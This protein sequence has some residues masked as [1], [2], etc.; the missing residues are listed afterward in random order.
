MDIAGKQVVITATVGDW[1][2]ATAAETGD[3]RI[4]R[5]RAW[6]VHRSDTP[7]EE[8]VEPAAYAMAPHPEAAESVAGWRAVMPGH[9]I[10]GTK[11]GFGTAP[12]LL[13]AMDAASAW[14]AAR[15]GTPALEAHTPL[16]ASGITAARRADA[17]GCGHATQAGEMPRR[18]EVARAIAKAVERGDMEEAAA[19]ALFASTLHEDPSAPAATPPT[20]RQREVIRREVVRQLRKE[21]YLVAPPSVDRAPIVQRLAELAALP[22][23]PPG[24]PLV[25]AAME[26]AEVAITTAIEVAVADER[27]TQLAADFNRLMRAVWVLDEEGRP[28]EARPRTPEVEAALAEMRA[29]RPTSGP[30]F[31]W[32][33][34]EGLSYDPP[35][36]PAEPDRGKPGP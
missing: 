12:S 22:V 10:Y 28:I 36:P 29:R 2:T 35:V 3:P 8:K 19:L 31:D 32:M 4:T 25:L 1:R 9:G 18:R 20:E 30:V 11:A 5:W 27:E 24:S 17:I 21:G 13:D 34:R 23:L 14:I 33:R 7:L 26:A 6:T 16:M 15:L